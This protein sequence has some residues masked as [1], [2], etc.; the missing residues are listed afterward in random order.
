MKTKPSFR[1]TYFIYSLL[2]FL[3]GVL[4]MRACAQMPPELQKRVDKY[5]SKR[6]DNMTGT[7]GWMPKLGFTFANSKVYIV[8]LNDTTLIL[9]SQYKGQT[10]IF[11]N[12]I[13]T[14]I[15]DSLYTTAQIDKASINRK[16]E[17]DATVTEIVYISPPD[18]GGMIAALYN[19]PLEE[20]PIRL[21]GGNATVNIILKKRDLEMFRAG[22]ELYLYLNKK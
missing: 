16:V 21:M 3:I 7:T 1:K 15:G 10:W 5:Y 4:S 12:S 11:H 20:I 2:L 19:C 6:I 9:A 13:M 14:R 18:D 22:Y 17:H 8:I